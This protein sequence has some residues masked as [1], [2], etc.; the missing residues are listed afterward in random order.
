MYDQYDQTEELEELIRN[1]KPGA[2]LKVWHRDNDPRTFLSEE[3]C[4]SVPPYEGPLN[5]TGFFQVVDTPQGRKFVAWGFG[6]AL[7]IAQSGLRPEDEI[8]VHRPKTY[9][10]LRTMLAKLEAG[11]KISKAEISEPGSYRGWL[12]PLWPFICW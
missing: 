1:R 4:H 5:Y 9:S 12:W 6:I 2:K 8:K 3:A 11:E 7:C 10:E